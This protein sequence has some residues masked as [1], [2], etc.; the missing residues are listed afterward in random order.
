MKNWNNSKCISVFITNSS[1]IEESA[2]P[3][4]DNIFY[5]NRDEF[6]DWTERCVRIIKELLSSFTTIGDVCWRDKAFQLLKD[7]R[8][9]PQDY[10][11]MIVSKPLKKIPVKK[12]K[13][14]KET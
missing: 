13:V 1:K 7:N 4:A 14:S 5:L 10:E 3:Q 6:A 11:K 2:L 8:L 9:M 12:L